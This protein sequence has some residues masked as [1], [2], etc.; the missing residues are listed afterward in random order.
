MKGDMTVEING[1]TYN[2]ILPE[3]IEDDLTPLDCGMWVSYTEGLAQTA[4][5]IRLAQKKGF[6]LSESEEVVVAAAEKLEIVDAPLESALAR[7]AIDFVNQH[8]PEGYRLGFKVMD[9]WFM[10]NSWWADTGGEE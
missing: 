4:I 9:L 1:K 2:R 8:A 7:R 3:G 5:L 6:E 10:P